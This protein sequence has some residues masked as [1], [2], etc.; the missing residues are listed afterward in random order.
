MRIL[1]RYLLGQFLGWSA[2]GLGTLVAFF[3]VVDLFERI[4]V[5]VDYRTPLPIILRFYAYGLTTILIQVVPLVLLLGTLL[6]LGQLRRFQ[7]LTAMQ[8]SGCSPWR[9]ARPLLLAALLVSIA[10]YG[11]AEMFAADHYAEKQRILTEEIKRLSG[12]DRESQSAVRLLGRGRRFFVAQFY[13]ARS[14]TLRQVSLQELAPPSLSRRLD[15]ERAQYKDGVWR[16]EQGFYRT[17]EDGKE[18]V[19]AFGAYASTSIE[20]QPEDFARR[21]VDPFVAGMAELRRLAQRVG[22]SGGEVQEYWTDFHLRASYPLSGLILV[23][24]GAGL[25]MRVIRGGGVVYGIGISIAVGFAYLTLIRI[26]Q[27]FGYEGVLPPPL[28]AWMAN[29]LFAGLGSWIFWRVAR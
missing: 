23:L 28:A 3:I 5:F 13:D 14:Q 1:D 27:A 2:I 20:E 24:L 7:E 10:Q 19:R 12:A 11:V 8:A 17:F 16:F 9:L 18:T 25:S 22:E 4:D 29:L 6:S 26:G 15:A 21:K